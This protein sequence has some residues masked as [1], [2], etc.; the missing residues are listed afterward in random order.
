MNKCPKC[1]ATMENNR[2]T[3]C[4]YVAQPTPIVVEN[5]SEKSKVVA[6]LLCFFLG[7]FGAHH[8]YV[9]RYLIMHRG[10]LRNVPEK[11]FQTI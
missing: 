11:T 2:C 6:A 8:F 1:G 10:L 4:D 7:G 9:R 5:G 3:F